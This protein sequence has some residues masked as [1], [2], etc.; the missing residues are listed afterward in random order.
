MHDWYLTPIV[1][2]RPIG[3]RHQSHFSHDLPKRL[4]AGSRCRPRRSPTNLR[5]ATLKFTNLAL[6]RWHANSVGDMQA[7]RGEFDAGRRRP[8]GSFWKWRRRQR[9]QRR[10]HL[11]F[12]YILSE[13]RACRA[14]GADRTTVRYRATRPDESALR[15]R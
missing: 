4:R 15:D 14:L 5:R 3:V 13:R 2:T 1:C 9:I 8:E 7:I 11:H 12:P 6:V 10:V